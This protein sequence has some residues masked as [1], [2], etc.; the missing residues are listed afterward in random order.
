M[1]PGQSAPASPTT[2]EPAQASFDRAWADYVEWS[3]LD[4]A[5]LPEAPRDATDRSS[6]K[7]CPA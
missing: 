1:S 6:G 3:G 7:A 5:G 4:E 2:P